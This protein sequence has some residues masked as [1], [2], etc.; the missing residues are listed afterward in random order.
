M[1]DEQISTLDIE[2]YLARLYPRIE[3]TVG[4]DILCPEC[5]EEYKNM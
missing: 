2:N 4:T 3:Q 5:A 1:T